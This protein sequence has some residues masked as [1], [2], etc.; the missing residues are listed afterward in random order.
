[1]AIPKQRALDYVEHEWGTY[2]ERFNRLPEE[3]QSKRVKEMGYE[4]F[5]DLLAHILAWWE[6]GMG[7]LL[8]IAQ[9]RPF[10]RKKYDFDVFNAEA[11][12]KY[13]PWEESEFMAHFE[14]TRQQM[15][16]DLKSMDAALFENRRVAAWLNGIILHHAREHLAA[17]SPFLALDMLENN[18]ATYI[19]DFNCLEPEAQKEFL[20]KQG[21]GNFH[22]L[23]AHIIGW[24]EEGA[25][26]ITGILN[27]PGFEWQ[28]PETDSF[29]LELTKKFSTWSDEDLVSHYE[30]VRLALIDLVERLP[31]DAFLNKDIEGW[32]ASDVVKH[33]DDHPIPHS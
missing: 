25:R 15:G 1:V 31:E 7:I 17:L 12:A 11:V 16:A 28:D 6:E 27:S 13:K 26:I 33:Y 21:V 30:S 19:A 32:L 3:E 23:L 22:D 14:K 5:R 29:N 2:V 20:S 9:E 8:A 18:W 24:W 4:S 10:E